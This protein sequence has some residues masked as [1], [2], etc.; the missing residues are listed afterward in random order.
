MTTDKKPIALLFANLKGNVGDFAILEAILRDLDRHFPGRTVKLF[1]HSNLPIDKA[2]VRAFEELSGYSLVISTPIQL[3]TLPRG[4]G[5]L[6]R[7][8][9]WSKFQAVLVKALSLSQRNLARELR[10]CEFVCFAGGD[11]WNGM[12]LGPAM[13]AAASIA[14]RLGKKIYC[15][16]F[17]CNPAIRKFNSPHALRK[18]FSRI[19]QPLIVRDSISSRTIS[20]LGVNVV[21]GSDCV[22]GLKPLIENKGNH[23]QNATRKVIISLTSAKGVS[24]ATA[25]TEIVRTLRT[26]GTPFEIEVLSTC[27]LEDADELEDC[28]ELEGIKKSYPASWQEAVERFQTASLV[29]TNR[30]H[31]LIL[32]SL[33]DVPVLPLTNREKSKAFAIDADLPLSCE[34]AA[35]VT[36]ETVEASINSREET[37]AKLRA[38]SDAGL[39]DIHSPFGTARRPQPRDARFIEI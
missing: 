20:D 7:L 1:P 32:C 5:L 15:Y 17:S 16:P 38:F 30:L 10:D 11:Q 2:R 39:D 9:V 6:L 37:L 14:K 13:F 23:S 22:F 25:T 4:V 21:S 26:E 35:E 19:S 3:P 12:R 34:T 29:V 33:S 18:S 27:E 24:A 8:G 31:A 28:A 36:I